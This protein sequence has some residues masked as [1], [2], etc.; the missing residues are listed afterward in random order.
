MNN[1]EI[2]VLRLTLIIVFLV[3]VFIANVFI[4]EKYNSKRR[5]HLKKERRECIAICVVLSIGILTL[6]MFFPASAMDLCLKYK[7]TEIMTF[8]GY[9]SIGY[10]ARAIL[11]YEL[12]FNDDF[13][14]WSYSEV[15][16]SHRFIGKE[17]TKYIVTYTNRAHLLVDIQEYTDSG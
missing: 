3:L 5:K 1:I 9:G 7:K 2:R 15:I 8:T 4:Y 12:E 11:G 13:N 17:G 6:M 10:K 16:D 14:C